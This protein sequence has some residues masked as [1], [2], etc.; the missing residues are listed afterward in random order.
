MNRRDFLRGSAACAVAAAVPLPVAMV[1]APLV[2]PYH[3]VGIFDGVTAIYHGVPM[4]EVYSVDLLGVARAGL[5]QWA[6]ASGTVLAFPLPGVS[7]D[8]DGRA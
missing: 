1:E 6:A 7:E 5:R 2:A 8:V 4:R 3:V